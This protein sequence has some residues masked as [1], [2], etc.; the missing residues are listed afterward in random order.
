MT[1]EEKELAEI[2]R[3]WV[4]PQKPQ[5][6]DRWISNRSLFDAILKWH[7]KAAGAGQ[8]KETER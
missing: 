2:L 4:Y 5:R 3:F 6:S 1:D 8:S 7:K